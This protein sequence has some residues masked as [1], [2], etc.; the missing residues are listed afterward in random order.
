MGSCQSGST[1]VV[2]IMMTKSG[3]MLRSVEGIPSHC[4]LRVLFPICNT[5]IAQLS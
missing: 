4:I 3:L 1:R 5:P 2:T